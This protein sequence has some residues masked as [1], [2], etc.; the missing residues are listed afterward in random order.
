MPTGHNAEGIDALGGAH[1][2]AKQTT[3]LW[4]D[5]KQACM[6]ASHLCYHMSGCGMHGPK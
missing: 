6:Y 3:M 5:Q 1:L 2:L 4:Q